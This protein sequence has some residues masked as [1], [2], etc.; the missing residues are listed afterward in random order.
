MYTPQPFEMTDPAEIRGLMGRGL[1]TFV[2]AT[3][4]GP[5]ATPLPFC[6][7]PEEGPRGT[8]Y[9]HF[10]R[11]NPHW[12]QPMIGQAMVL[13]PGVDFY[14]SPSWYASK[15]DNGKVVPTWNYETVQAFG[16]PE[17]FH[18]PRRLRDLV[19]RMTNRYEAGRSE[20]WA[21]S[22]APVTFIEAQLRGIVGLRLPISRILA[23]KKMSQNRVTADRAGVRTGLE[24]DGDGALCPH[25]P[26]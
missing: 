24:A 3:E 1:A 11:A 16:V 17:F 22:D 5:V 8:L 6:L 23:K 21:V 26:E 15:Q 18:E 12:Q 20:P 13:F 2:T 4:T 19:T 25:V 14:V 10:A 9:A 7:V